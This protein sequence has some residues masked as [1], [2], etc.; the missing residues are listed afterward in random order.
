MRCIIWMAGIFLAHGPCLGMPLQ[1]S[2]IC[3]ILPHYV[4]THRTIVGE[5]VYFLADVGGVSKHFR[6]SKAWGSDFSISV[7]V[8]DKGQAEH[9]YGQFE[10]LGYQVDRYTPS[11][12]LDLALPLPAREGG[13]DL[14]IPIKTKQTLPEIIQSLS[15]KL[16][17]PEELMPRSLG[18]IDDM[19]RWVF[20][21]FAGL[22]NRRSKE[23]SDWLFSFRTSGY[24]LIQ[25]PLRNESGGVPGHISQQVAAIDS[26]IQE[27]KL[28]RK[29]TLYH[30]DTSPALE[31]IWSSGV[32]SRGVNLPVDP[33]Y[34]FA[35]MLKSFATWWRT[36]QYKGKGVILE[37]EA[38]EG[39]RMIPMEK[40]RSEPEWLTT[41]SELEFLLPRNSRFV[42]TGASLD[43]DG[44]KI[45]HCKLLP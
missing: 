14:L 42:A 18:N 10:S 25:G 33:A 41:A 37:I 45:L 28:D 27:G 12:S 17:E 4:D 2:N 38:D 34:T 32:D 22:K 16:V 11:A 8:E 43:S 21:N 23:L 9:L 44:N 35:S 1:A 3:Q 15:G 13:L 20:W 5:S 30:A 36:S 31:Q 24:K 7:R 6:I 19:R 40:L 29:I 39:L 26:A